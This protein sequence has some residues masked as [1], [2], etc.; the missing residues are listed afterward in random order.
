MR[1][2]LRGAFNEFFVAFAQRHWKW[3]ALMLSG[4]PLVSV[5]IPAYKP[6]FLAA[7]LDSVFAQTFRDFEVIVVNDGSPFDVEAA[8]RPYLE[9]P[10]FH[11][12]KQAGGGAAVA[13]NHGLRLARGEYVAFLDDD[14]L[15]LPD[16]LEWQVQALAGRP[17][18]TAVG[19]GV[20]NIDQH[21]FAKHPPHLM[22]RELRF[23]DLFGFCPFSTPGQTLIRAAEL[24]ACGGFNEALTIANDYDLWIRLSQRARIEIRPVPCLLYRVHESG[25]SKRNAALC[26]TLLRIARHHLRS[27]SRRSRRRLGCI[28]YDWIYEYRGRRVLNEGKRD[29]RAG[30]MAGALTSARVTCQFLR[31]ALWDAQ[32]LRKICR[33]LLPARLFAK[34]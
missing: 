17:E 27:A 9:R 14:D 21:G 19:G 26:Q 10:G 25:A 2:G 11:Y 32:L 30:D 20:Q 18:V 22:E 1:R 29:L 3:L 4:P 24:R 33:D 5:I 16:K 8:V 23:E 34:Q 13:R 7:T 6:Q 31:Y 28:A 12:V 15:W